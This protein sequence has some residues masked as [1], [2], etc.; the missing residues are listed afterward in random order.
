MGI[1]SIAGPSE[2]AIL[3][4]GE[5]NTPLEWIAAD[6]VAQAEHGENSKTLL[7]THITEKAKK[8]ANCVDSVESCRAF[9]DFFNKQKYFS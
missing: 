6:L 2:I 3:L 1:D 7:I 9:T 8:I 4:D 5:D